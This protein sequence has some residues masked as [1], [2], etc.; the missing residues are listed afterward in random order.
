MTEQGTD[1]DESPAQERRR[2]HDANRAELLDRQ[3]S[4]TESY[5]K[6]DTDISL[7]GGHSVPHMQK[8]DAGPLKRG[9]SIPDLQPVS[10]PA[11][12]AAPQSGITTTT[13]P[14]TAAPANPST[15]KK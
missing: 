2:L 15:L 10:A 8:V 5:D 13:A 6:V 12:T 7:S 4:N 14:M 1:D 11:Q 9:Q 3:R